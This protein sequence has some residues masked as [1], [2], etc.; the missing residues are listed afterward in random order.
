[1]DNKLGV[2]QVLNQLGY[3]VCKIDESYIVFTEF[4]PAEDLI[5]EITVVGKNISNII[6]QQMNLTGINKATLI[7]KL[8]QVSSQRTV[9]HKN[10]LYT[11]YIAYGSTI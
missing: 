8:D 4:Q 6:E 2:V 5:T 3:N 11:K 9:Y 1:M 10:T 7:N